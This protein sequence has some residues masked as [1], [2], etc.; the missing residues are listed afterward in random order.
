ML[1]HALKEEGFTI[2]S[3]CPGWVQT[4]M[5]QRA[6]D[7]VRL[8]HSNFTF[9]ECMVCKQAYSSLTVQ[10]VAPCQTVTSRSCCLVMHML[11]TRLA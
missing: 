11:K 6:A 10:N 9:V 1:A 4:D 7:D 3:M 5:G 2:I 8:H